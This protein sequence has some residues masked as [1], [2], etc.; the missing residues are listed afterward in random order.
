[1]VQSKSF[2]TFPYISY[3][4]SY[5]KPYTISEYNH[6]F[7]NENLHENFPMLGSWSSFHDYDAIYQ[8]NY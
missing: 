1:M 8:Y 3:G 4:K 2:G 6:P 7:P 5:Y